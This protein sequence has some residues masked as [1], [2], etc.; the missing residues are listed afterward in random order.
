MYQETFR[1]ISMEE[2]CE[3]LGKHDFI[4][5]GVRSIKNTVA[6]EL[7]HTE[8]RTYLSPSGTIT[9]VVFNVAGKEEGTIG[10]VVIVHTS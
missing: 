9:E 6:G 4:E 5:V 1:G 10:T 8:T 7:I 3:W 2:M